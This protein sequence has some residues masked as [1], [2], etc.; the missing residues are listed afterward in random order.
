VSDGVRA[1]LSGFGLEHPAPCDSVEVMAL[2]VSGETTAGMNQW[3]Q[4]GHRKTGRGGL[5]GSKGC[6]E[7]DSSGSFAV[8]RMTAETCND[9]D[10][11][12]HKGNGNGKKQRQRQKTTATATAAATATAKSNGSGVLAG[13]RC[14][15]P[16]QR[17]RWKWGTRQKPQQRQQ[18]PAC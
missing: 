1:C 3:Q 4:G 2:E 15:R 14:S 8:L 17:A 6:G 13:L 12:N 5:N 10:N 11:D 18:C 7:W 16:L 9:H